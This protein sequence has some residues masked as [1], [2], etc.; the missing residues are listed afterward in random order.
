MAVGVVHSDSAAVIEEYCRKEVLARGC[1]YIR[2]IPDS[3]HTGVRYENTFVLSSWAPG[4]QG[5]AAGSRD[6][7]VSYN[8]QERLQ[9]SDVETSVTSKESHPSLTTMNVFF[10]QFFWPTRQGSR[11]GRFYFCGSAVTPGNGHDLSLTSGFAV[12][13]ALGADFP[14]PENE[15]ALEDFGRVRRMMGLS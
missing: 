1:N 12:A 7:L 11:A 4:M 9:N 15:L 2:C 5:S 10:S 13:H 6:M 8:A 14:F 3:S